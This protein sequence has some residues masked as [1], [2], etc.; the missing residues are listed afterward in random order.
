MTATLEANAQRV[1]DK[2]L[3]AGAVGDLV[4]QEESSLSLKAHAGELEEHK[5]TS[6]RVY[7]VRVVKDDRAGIAYS[8]AS[9]P[10]ALD[11]MVEQ[12][13][14]NASFARLDPTENVADGA[15]ALATDDATLCPADPTSVEAKIDAALHLERELTAR[16]KVRNVPYNGVQDLTAERHVF[17]TTGRTAHSRNRVCSAFAYALLSDGDKDALEGARRH[18]RRFTEIDTDWIVDETYQ[19]CLAMLD[20]EAIPSKHYDVLFDVENQADLFTVFLDMFSAKTARDGINPLRDKV[21]ERIAVDALTIRD[22]PLNA[23]GL[24]Y[25]LFDDEGLATSTTTL[26]DA[27]V[28]RTLVHNS[29]TASHF[30]VPNTRNAA[31]SPRS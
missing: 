18:A 20:G 19:R 24:G 6:T 29:A 12:A 25:A 2:V 8:E 10:T 21:G 16:D 17:A 1:L 13:L 14:V 22:V 23:D 31:R 30:D 28:L 11:S 15:T 26:V 3:A 9:D 4:V 27:G 7:G 5:V